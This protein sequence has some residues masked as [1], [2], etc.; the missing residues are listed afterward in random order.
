MALVQTFRVRQVA[1][2]WGKGVIDRQGGREGGKRGRG[3]RGR[4]RRDI[5]EIEGKRKVVGWKQERLQG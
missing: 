2:Q 5:E 4:G 3:V 1:L